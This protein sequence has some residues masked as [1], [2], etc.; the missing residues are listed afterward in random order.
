[1][2][3]NIELQEMRE[4]LASFK[5][6]LAGQKI[7]NDR[8]MRKA[9]AEKASRL[10]KHKNT[11]LVIGIL[12]ILISIPIFYNVGFPIPFLAYTLVMIIFSMVMTHIYHRNVEKADFMGGNLKDV[13]TELVTL[14]KRYQQWY[15]IGGPLVAGYMT[16][17]YYYAPQVDFSP[18]AIRSFIIGGTVGA[19]IGAIIGI[20]MNNKVI[21][22]CDEIIRDI[23]SD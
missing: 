2:E 18:E 21:R 17:F 13:I 3:N 1:M 16:L 7:I 6:Q 4:Q 19:V 23:E 5:Q 22:L 20:R 15:W 8:L 14:K 11:H 12:G 9:T 10:K